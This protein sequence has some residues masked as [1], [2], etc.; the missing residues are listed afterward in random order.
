MWKKSYK[1]IIVATISSLFLLI[2]SYLYNN[3]PLSLF[4]DI[5]HY[6]WLELLRQKLGFSEGAEDDVVYINVSYDKKLIPVNDEYEMPIGNIDITDREK[7][8]QLLDLLNG[9]DYK[10]IFMD[11][12]FEKGFA[13][14]DPYIAED[15]CMMTVDE[16]LFSLI[17]HTPRL[18]VANHSDIELAADSIRSKT[19]LSD[20]MST[21]TA[22]NFVRYEY[23]QDGQESVPLH[24][25]RE[26]TGREITSCGLMYFDEGSLCYKSPFLQ[27]PRDFD[28]NDDDSKPYLNMGADILN[29]EMGGIGSDLK[30]L[31]KGKYVVIGDFV[32]DRHDTYIGMQPG[33]YI[34]SVATNYLFA[35]KHLVN[36]LSVV[37][38]G[39]VYFLITLSMFHKK[40][41]VTPALNLIRFNSRTS[42]FMMSFLGITFAMYLVTDS[43]Y[44]IEG[45]TFCLWIPSFYFTILRTIIIY[46]KK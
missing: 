45:E 41:V 24:I 4:D 7:L 14:N 17:I 5:E 31:V 10:Y 46:K 44:L 9:A 28:Q 20:Y 22:T 34:S 23:L 43:I 13:D 40:S 6:T 32:N 30:E 42:R 19:A 21:I 39:I 37:I 33:S 38:M 25:Y 12:R 27:I 26:M 29:E 18:V 16:K 36:W 2:A 35:G 11:V 1:R 15:S 3:S 8:S